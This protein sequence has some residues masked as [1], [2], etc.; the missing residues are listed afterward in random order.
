MTLPLR[1]MVFASL[2]AALIIVG[3]YLSVPL[4]F[5]PVPLVLADLFIILAGLALGASWGAVGIGMFLLLGFL[6]LPVF[7]GGKAGLPVLFGPTGG[8][9]I[10]YLCGG[11]LTGY[12]ANRG[13]KCSGKDVV[14]ISL[15]HLV[16][17]LCG[18]VWLATGMKMGWQKAFAVGMLPFL[19]GSLLKAV[20]EWYLIHPLRKIIAGQEE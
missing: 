2:F 1:K 5:S 11:A 8:Y 3:G 13:E 6:G 9:L 4:P 16:I 14:A 15:G 18:T 12:F 17:L 20:A 10:G 7:A 19:P